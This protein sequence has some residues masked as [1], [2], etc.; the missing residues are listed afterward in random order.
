MRGVTSCGAL[1]VG[2]AHQMADESE[3]MVGD[4]QMA[5]EGDVVAGEENMMDEDMEE[6][7]P[8]DEGEADG[9]NSSDFKPGVV[10][11]VTDDGG[12]TKEIITPGKGWEKPEKEDQVEVH[13]VGTLED[14]TKFDSSRDRGDP[15]TFHLGKGE[16]IKGWDE[17]VATMKKG[18][19]AILT[20]KPEYAY[21][22]S[23]SPPKIPENATLKFEVE[24]LNWKSIKDIS[25][26]G[27]VIKKILKE[28]EDW[29][30]PKDRDE[31]IVKYRAKVKGSEEPFASSEEGTE[32]IVKEG[33]L[34]KA[35]PIAVKKMKKGE[36]ALVT[37]KPDYAFGKEGLKPGVP[38]DS[39]LEIDL[40]L[41]S[42]KKVEDVTDDGLI[43]RK[44]LKKGKS[45]DKPKEGATVTVRYTGR[46]QNG[47]VFEERGEGNEHS[48][49]TDEEQVIEGLDRAIMKMDKGE[50]AEITI[51]PKYAFGDSDTAREKAT[52]PGG[53]TVIYE[54]E[55]TE[56]QNPKNTW[57]MSNAEKIEDAKEKKEKGNAAYKAGR[58]ERAVKKYEAA[59][60]VIEYDKDF[61]D[62]KQASKDLKKSA[63]LNLAAAH[64]KLQNYKY[65]IDNCTKALEVDPVNVKALY[66]R[67]Q[68]Y[69]GTS[70]FIEAEMDIKKAREAEPNDKDLAILYSKMRKQMKAASKKEA[71]I[72]STMF[73]KLAK[74]KEPDEN[75]ATAAN[76]HADVKTSETEDA[77]KPGPSPSSGS[78]ADA[79]PAEAEAE[80]MES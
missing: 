34:C 2:A 24:L 80:P 74:L 53:S 10:K 25:G 9:N 4:E 52:V 75:K 42:W 8:M 50:K 7:E 14:G 59:V 32:F 28:G 48:F 46:L 58:L 29:D 11:N 77:G 22:A 73:S 18:E 61:G 36:K 65:V 17:G 20:C 13:Y 40:E 1:A 15:F 12:V 62:M 44:V 72:Y 71:Q 5:D 45:Y 47:T 26:D 60:R 66:R 68:A 33:H 67:A 21:G 51:A 19:K 63:W 57:D 16:V 55:I 64:L 38:S 39:E 56:V 79:E 30:N 6:D 78:K 70:D 41:V 76:G 27:G 3:K 35:L 31:V 37:A 49:V 43:I 23:G 69:M 54:I